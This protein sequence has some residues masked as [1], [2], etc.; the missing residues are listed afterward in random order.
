MTSLLKS[1]RFNEAAELGLEWLT[2]SPFDVAAHS[3]LAVA[4][5]Q[6]G[7]L[8]TAARHLGYVMMLRSDAEHAH[9]QLHQIVLSLAKTPDGLQRLRDIAANAPDSPRM[10]DELAWLLATYPD[11]NTRDGAEAVL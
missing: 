2:V 9:A 10:L 3:A 7:D 4:M 11:S 8:A 6:T 1:A 5:A